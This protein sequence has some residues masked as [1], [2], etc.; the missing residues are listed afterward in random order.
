MLAFHEQEFRRRV[1]NATNTVRR[2]LHRTRSPVYAAEAAHSYSDKFVLCNM[3][4]R[5]ALGS[6]FQ[7]LSVAEVSDQDLATLIEWSQDQAVSLRLAGSESCRFVQEQSREEESSERKTVGRKG[8]QTSSTS[9]KVVTKITEYQWK[10]EGEWHLSAFRGVG[11]S[12]ADQI[13][14]SSQV[15]SREVI[16]GSKINPRAESYVFPNLEVDISWLLRHF[17][18]SDGSP[19][20]EI[21]REVESCRTPRRNKDI[22]DALLCT[23]KISTWCASVR[24]FFANQIIAAL[25]LK[26]DKPPDILGIN[27]QGVFVPVVPLCI[28][29]SDAEEMGQLFFTPTDITALL[30]E[31]KRSLAAR[32]AHFASASPATENSVRLYICVDHLRDIIVQLHQGVDYVE[33]ML[34][35]Q[36][37]AA[38]GRELS[39]NDFASF[40]R[41][42]DR[43]LFRDE[44]QPLPFSYAV[45]RSPLHSPEGLV[46][47]EE[48]S[49]G[50]EGG[51]SEPVFT[52]VRQGRAAVPM[53]FSL[54][55]A[56]TVQFTGHRALHA[57]LRTD[58][59]GQPAPAVQLSASAR[60]LS[61]FIV[62][63]GRLASADTFEPTH[64]MIVQNKDEIRVPLAISTIPTPKEFKDA[65]SSLSPEQQAFCQ[66]YRAMQLESSLFAICVIQVKP[67][68]ERVLNLPP[69]SLAKEIKLTQDLTE[70]FIKHQIPADL[71]TAGSIDA[72]ALTSAS[73][74]FEVVGRTA[75]EKVA[76]VK[77]H[78]DA[79]TQ[80]IAAEKGKQLTEAAQTAVYAAIHYSPTSPSYSPMSPSYKPSSAM[81]MEANLDL[82]SYEPMV[83]EAEKE[84]APRRGGR[85][86]QTPRESTGGRAPALVGKGRAD[87]AGSGDRG[88]KRM[89]RE[90]SLIKLSAPMPS[91]PSLTELLY[92]QSSGSMAPREAAGLAAKRHQHPTDGDTRMGTGHAGRQGEPAKGDANAG[93]LRDKS[94]G[95]ALAGSA[96]TTE[97]DGIDYIQ[98]PAELD[99]RLRE[100]D[101]A[102]AVRPT[103]I[104]AGETW[105]KQSMPSLLSAEAEAH[106]LGAAELRAEKH[107]AFELLDALTRSGA[108]VIHEA[109]LHVVIAATHTFDKSLVDTVVQNNFNPIEQV[110]RSSLI[111]ASSVV[112]KHPSQLIRSAHMDR[113]RSLAPSLFSDVDGE[114]R[115]GEA[116]EAAAM[117]LSAD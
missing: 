44:T 70:L 57:W 33:D 78:V 28:Q 50:N 15:F 29:N 86:K 67:L 5:L 102:N 53:R 76:E 93:G 79:M 97:M 89:K 49:G 117:R 106:E 94:E 108:L 16:T 47:I 82:D 7:T 112:A 23:S 100:E 8:N 107:R 88:E 96:G 101:A 56:T 34:R 20:F 10:V 85:T 38:V 19:D 115:L 22:D 91:D 2:I 98:V 74:D 3:L 90:Q 63:V 77:G 69:E 46:A 80:L 1:D 105:R 73:S 11:S 24:G 30:D 21:K 13:S 51:M 84:V 116:M 75:G 110:E 31:Q 43:K 60:Q 36:L 104:K 58:F 99:R 64:A 103:I 25:G 6:I 68:L 17:R 18:G 48:R 42:N 39:S 81:A 61:S 83:M 114:E 4:V 111:M 113:L 109:S 27:T 45:R 41:F 35:Q 72:T 65:I 32:I 62:L 92:K 26:G 37:F 9:S 55:A 14:I 52:H 12:N 54:N 59:C 95:S 71:L 66:A 40:R 87:G